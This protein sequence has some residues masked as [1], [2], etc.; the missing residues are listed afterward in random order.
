MLFRSAFPAAPVTAWSARS[1][2]S[3][4]EGVRLTV[5]GPDERILASFLY[6]RL[7]LRAEPADHPETAETPSEEHLADE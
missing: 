1:L 2:V 4:S 6:D 3:P 5:A 7:G